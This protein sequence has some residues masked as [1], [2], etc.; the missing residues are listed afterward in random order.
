MPCP[1]LTLVFSCPFPGET[2]GISSGKMEAAT[3]SAFSRQAGSHAL[4]RIIAGMVSGLLFGLLLLG[5]ILF[6]Y[7]KGKLRYG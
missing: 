1:V 2:L 4:N 7:R 5:G 3:G 6:L